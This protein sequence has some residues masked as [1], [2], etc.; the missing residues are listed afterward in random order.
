MK[1]ICQQVLLYPVYVHLYGCPTSDDYKE[2]LKL[3]W[4]KKLFQKD[5]INEYLKHFK[6]NIY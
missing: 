2:Y 4:Y 1:C 5:P 3:K 6:K